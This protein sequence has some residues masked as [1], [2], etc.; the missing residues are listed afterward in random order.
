[1]LEVEQRL[2]R[3]DVSTTTQNVVDTII[4]SLQE[5]IDAVAQAKKDSQE[6]SQRNQNSGSQASQDEQS[7]INQLSELRM[8]RTMQRRVNERTVRFEELLVE[9]KTDLAVLE[10]NVDELARQQLRIR[11]ILR[12]MSLGRNR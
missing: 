8:I 6:R 3:G 2:R 10:K 5:M 11:Q 7:L 12:D 1:M 4:D 9:G